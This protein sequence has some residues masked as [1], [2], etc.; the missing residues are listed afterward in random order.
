[1][2]K[3]IQEKYKVFYFYHGIIIVGV[4]SW[5]TQGLTEAKKTFFY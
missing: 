4:T 2:F 5:F 1:M 3:R